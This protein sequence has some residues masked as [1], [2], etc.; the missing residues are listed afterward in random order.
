MVISGWLFFYRNTLPSPSAIDSLLKNAPTQTLTPKQPFYVNTKESRFYIKP[1][2]EYHL[3]GLVVS[4]YNARKKFM[5]RID[6][7]LNL[8]D[9]CVL[10][11][12]NSTK[13]VYEQVSFWSGEV[14][15]YA[16]SKPPVYFYGEKY[17]QVDLDAIPHD[18]LIFNIDLF[19]NNH[20]LTENKQLG[21]LL[22][23]VNIGEQISISGYLVDYGASPDNIYRRTSTVR[24]DTGNGACE[25][26]YVTS[27]A[28]L[29]KNSY[30]QAYNLSL[31]SLF[32]IFIMWFA[33]Q[34][35][36]L[37]TKNNPEQ[38]D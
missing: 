2:Y 36:P 35:T 13:G 28:T 10:W 31:A 30:R 24:T 3:Y 34:L 25:T 26:I 37:T 20:L 6:K 29:H 16:T 12:E 17:K 8:A 23:N 15:C 27:F 22:R 5:A 21:K 1:L 9:I 32:C 38:D 19:S 14:T 7:D 18:A 4:K 33:Y 11:G